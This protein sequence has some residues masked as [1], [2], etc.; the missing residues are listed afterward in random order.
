M[1]RGQRGLPLLLADLDEG[2]V[3]EFL[4]YGKRVKAKFPDETCTVS[5]NNY[6]YA[7]VE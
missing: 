3:L 6:W 2:E 4:Y 1:E 5:L 7:V